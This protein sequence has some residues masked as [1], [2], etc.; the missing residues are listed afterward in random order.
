MENNQNQNLN[1]NQNDSENIVV[2]KAKLAI[3]RKLMQSITEELEKVNG[4]LTPMLGEEDWQKISLSQLTDLAEFD[5]QTNNI[6][7]GIFDGEKM[8]GPDGKQYNVPVNYASKSKLVEGDMLKLAITDKGT[9]IYK[10]IAPIERLRLIGSLQKTPSGE[11]FVLVGNKKW[12]VLTAS[13]TYYKGEL[14]DE[15]VILVP[16]TGISKWAAVENIF[17]KKLTVV[18]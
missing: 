4:L 12:R 11:F 17:K 3:M 8:I 2:S 5:D 10:Q 7:E 13:V 14:E 1:K 6:V 16:K 15:V 9:F 18:A